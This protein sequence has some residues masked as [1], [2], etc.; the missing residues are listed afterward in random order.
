MVNWFRKSM[1]DNAQS[2]QQRRTT[3]TMP[4]C[5]SLLAIS[6]ALR[7]TRTTPNSRPEKLIVPKDGPNAFLIE[8]LMLRGGDEPAFQK[9]H[10]EIV[11]LIM[12]T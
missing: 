5:P 3:Y 10:C 6:T 4:S 8:F 9:Y 11:P 7:T 1:V 12:Y 2:T